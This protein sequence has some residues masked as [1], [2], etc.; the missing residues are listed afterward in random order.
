MEFHRDINFENLILKTSR[1]FNRYC[2]EERLNVGEAT[3]KTLYELENDLNKNTHQL[4][5]Y[6]ELFNILFDSEANRSILDKLL[7]QLMEVSQS[8]NLDEKKELVDFMGHNFDFISK[9]TKIGLYN[10]KQKGQSLA[11]I[12]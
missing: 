2:F 7:N 10:K 11:L 1:L 5:A 12:V 8:L 4:V 9:M 6:V 3:G